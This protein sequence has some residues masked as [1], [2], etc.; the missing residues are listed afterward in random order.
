MFAVGLL[1]RGFSE[2]GLI[3]YNLYENYV[4]HGVMIG[5]G[6]VALIQIGAIVFRNKK[7][8]QQQSEDSDELRQSSKRIKSTLIKGATFY[9]LT[10]LALTFISQIFVTMT[11][12]QLI[13]SSF[14]RP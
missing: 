2:S 12:P 14:L 3:T 1:I 6:I 4:P 5:A 13:D 8:S 9:F 10:A 7:D 11:L